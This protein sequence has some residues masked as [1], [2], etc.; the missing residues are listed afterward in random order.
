MPGQN[1][2]KI[3]ATLGP[4]SSSPE[5]IRA[6]LEAG[7]DVFRLNK[8]ESRNQLARAVFFHRLGEIRDRSFENQAHRA[9]STCSSPPS[10]PGTP[11]ISGTQ[12][13]TYAT[14]A[15]MCP[16]SSS[17]TSGPRPGST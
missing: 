13:S 12:W 1:K 2:A 4:A 15:R 17:R 5:V 6:L 3:V 11:A 16:T 9:G 8:G 10:L 14:E 7:A